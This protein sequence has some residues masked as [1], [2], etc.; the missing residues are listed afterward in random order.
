M[1]T[2]ALV[3]VA[4]IASAAL[5]LGAAPRRAAAQDTFRDF[6]TDAF[7]NPWD[8][9][10]IADIIIGDGPML[11]IADATLASGTLRFRANG[12]GYVSPLWA[13]YP[14]ALDGILDGVRRPIDTSRY[15][16]IALR[17]TSNTS[18]AAGIRWYTC[19]DGAVN[20]SCQ[21]GFGFQVAPGTNTYDFAM[22]P[23]PG[24]PAL[25]TPW[26]GTATGIRL[27]FS[28][29]AE[30]ALDWVSIY[31]GPTPGD[32][33]PNAPVGRIID[34]D[35][36]GGQSLSATLRGREWDMGSA[37]DVTRMFN[38]TGSV[39]NGVF[40]GAN[41]G[42]QQ[43]DPSIVLNLACRTFR[44]EQFHRFTVEFTF[45]GPFNLEDRPG[46][47]MMQRLIWRIAG[48]AMAPDGRD[49]QNS[50]DMVIY[51]GRRRYSVD[52]VRNPPAAVTDP[53]QVGVRI[54]WLGELEHLR[55]DPNEDP[56][57]RTWHV[58]FVK[59]AAPDLVA[60]GASFGITWTDANY[61]PGGTAT[62]ALSTSPDGSNA[63]TIADGVSVQQ[64]ANRTPWTATGTGARW[65]V[66]TIRR[67]GAESRTVSTGPL[68]LGSLT[69]TL[70][71]NARGIDGTHDGQPCAGTG[72]APGA[73]AKAPVRAASTPKAKTT[74]TTAKTA[75]KTAAKKTTT[76]KTTA[77]KK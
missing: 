48:T 67:N 37:D 30:L 35:I 66:L 1:R 25:R 36:E 73:A 9:S 51:P 63:Q 18:I 10:D 2:L 64:G 38:A 44:A 45:D 58:D 68:V 76:K 39:S 17:I 77:K 43:N 34:P 20:D 54:G 15:G 59:V 50:E 42:P 40:N 27:A 53:G 4:L 28:G 7:G 33:G 71:T 72:A 14:G 26:S 46:G 56:G 11:G 19:P 55:F 69:P 41:A 8:Y 62:I 5:A 57:R 3:T 32:A 70:G 23:A 60:P 75:A 13:G 22:A 12:A 29:S 61:A 65:V 74:K 47:G 6:A 31:S 24:D 49:L 21:G 52:M 16:R